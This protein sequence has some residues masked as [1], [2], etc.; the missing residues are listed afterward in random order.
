MLWL[1]LGENS[2]SI[3]HKIH[4][5]NYLDPC[6]IVPFCAVRVVSC[7]LFISLF[8]CL[9]NP[10]WAHIYLGKWALFALAISE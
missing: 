10:E 1:Y 2:G 7:E 5:W 9:I 8:A 6:R 4:Q 3:I